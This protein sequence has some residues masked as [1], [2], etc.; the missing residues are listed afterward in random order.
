MALRSKV[1]K[2]ALAAAAAVVFGV[3]MQGETEA[4]GYQEL[5][6][7]YPAA[8][9]YAPSS[10]P[11]LSANVCFNAAGVTLMNGSSCPVNTYP[12]FLKYGEVIDPYTGAVQAYIALSDGCDMGYCEP[13]N[14]NDPPGEEGAMCCTV[15]G[16][17]EEATGICPG[18][19]IAHWCPNGQE[20]AEVNGQWICKEAD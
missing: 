10:A 2:V 20:A 9:E 14:P 17:C 7:S 6:T 4:N 11:V 8:C 1:F 3:G 18:D 16:G 19:K 13:H 15:G 12:F 5:C